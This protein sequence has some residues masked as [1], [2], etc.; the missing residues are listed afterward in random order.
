MKKSK[1]IERIEE[2]ETIYDDCIE[3][4]NYKKYEK[5]EESQ[6][7]LYKLM[8]ETLNKLNDIIKTILNDGFIC[9]NYDKQDNFTLDYQHLS[10]IEEWSNL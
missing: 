2:M 8:A 1:Q 5:K 9:F 4:I 3:S 6:E 7:E 10:R